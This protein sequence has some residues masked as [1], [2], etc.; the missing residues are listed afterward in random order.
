MKLFVL[1]RHALSMCQSEETIIICE[2][3]I[4]N[5]SGEQQE[6]SGLLSRVPVLPVPTVR[7]SELTVKPN[8][9]LN[10]SFYSQCKCTVLL[11]FTCLK[12][13]SVSLIWNTSLSAC[14]TRNGN[15]QNIKSFNFIERCVSYRS[16]ILYR[17]KTNKTIKTIK[18][19]HLICHYQIQL[20]LEH[21]W[22]SHLA[23]RVLIPYNRADWQEGFLSTRLRRKTSRYGSSLYPIRFLCF[24]MCQ[25]AEIYSL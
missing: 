6:V 1:L 4:V 10:A 13:E 19:I 7:A 16:D 3:K 14:G 21:L 25:C 5:C 20:T 15:E 11:Y 18:L 9:V 24:S 2:I 22:P 23:Q 12:F 17:K 8:C